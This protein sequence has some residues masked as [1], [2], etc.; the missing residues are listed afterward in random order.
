MSDEQRF[1]HDVQPLQRLGSLAHHSSD[2]DS[3]WERSSNVTRHIIA[4]ARGSGTANGDGAERAFAASDEQNLLK[5]W[6]GP[7]V[8]RPAQPPA[9]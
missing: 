2:P 6:D 8:V 5:A 4:T 3:Q 7:D 1:E 9:V